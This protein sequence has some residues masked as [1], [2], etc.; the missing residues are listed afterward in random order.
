M[1]AGATTG[2]AI[3]D[4]LRDL[5]RVRWKRARATVGLKVRLASAHLHHL[6]QRLIGDDERAPLVHAWVAG[7]RACARD[8][9]EMQQAVD[10]G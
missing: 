9:E 10:G 7:Y 3:P 4:D 1:S 2:L 6:S 5:T 8:L